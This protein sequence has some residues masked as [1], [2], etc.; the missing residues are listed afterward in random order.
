MHFYRWLSFAVNPVYRS[1]LGRTNLGQVRTNRV[2]R[3]DSPRIHNQL[4]LT[5]PLSR[6]S[7][8]EYFQR[9]PVEHVGTVAVIDDHRVLNP[10]IIS[11]Q[12]GA[13][14]ELIDLSWPFS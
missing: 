7:K 14:D 5:I 12:F 9:G 11:V 3:I 2:D 6:Q 13:R 8:K 1:R 10:R 4:D